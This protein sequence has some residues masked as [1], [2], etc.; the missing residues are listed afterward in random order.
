MAHPIPQQGKWAT[1]HFTIDMHQLTR[2]KEKHKEVYVLISSSSS[3]Y[4]LKPEE[5]FIG[6]SVKLS[7]E[8][9]TIWL[10]GHAIKLR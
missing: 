9:P 3:S 7:N 10:I 1:T 4:M 8:N 6:N 2:G 5:T